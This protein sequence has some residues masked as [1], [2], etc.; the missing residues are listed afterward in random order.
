M[1]SAVSCAIVALLAAAL[2]PRAAA[3]FPAELAGRVV[4]ARTGG[5]VPGAAITADRRITTHA[6]AD[7]SFRLRGLEPREQSVR[8][9][10]VGY[11]P[12]EIT[13]TLANG[14]RRDLRLELRAM[15]V[16]LPELQTTARATEA[17]VTVVGR[18]EIDESARPDLPSLLDGR[19]GLVVE[20][21]GGAGGPATVSVRGSSAD[22]VLVLLDGVPLNDAVSG[23]ADLSLIALESLDSVVVR[24]GG[25]SAR[26]GGRALAGVLE[27]YSRRPS[28]SFEAAAG[29]RA[30]AWGDRGASGMIAGGRGAPGQRLSGTLT[31]EFRH[32]DGDFPF[33]VP[34]VRG[35]GEARRV[36]GVSRQATVQGSGAYEWSRGELRL[37]GDWLDVDRGMPGTIVQQ[38][39]SA[40]QAQRRVSGGVSSRADLG[41][42]TWTVDAGV[43]RQHAGF[44]DSLPP[45]GGAYDDSL[46]AT[47]V[48][49][50]SAAAVVRG[51]FDGSVGVDLRLLDVDGS[52]LAATAPGSRHYGGLWTSLALRR[53]WGTDGTVQLSAG[54]RGDVGSGVGDA[55][56]SPKV[57]VGAQ[58][59][60]WGVTA[61]WGMSFSPPSLGDQ[62]F[63]EGVQVRANPNL[64]PE[65]VR[66]EFTLA[67]ELRE[68][69]VLG[70]AVRAALTGFAANVDG[71]ILWTPDFRY[72]WSPAN[73][74]IRRRGAEAE[75]GVR[76]PN[77][78]AGLTMNGAFTDMTYT[79][80]VLTG[81]VVYRPRWTGNV[82]AD[83]EVASVR[84]AA[85]FRAV[86]ARRTAIGSP[87]NQLPAFAVFDLSLARA[88]ALGSTV[89]EL[90]GGVDDLFDRRAALIVDYPSPGR[91]WWLGT[92]LTVGGR[93]PSSGA[94]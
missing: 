39:L 74:N 92:R 29:A 66:S 19:A 31:G 30:G 90:R 9:V 22:E 49:V 79:G 7:G 54:A 86:G 67:L 45:F 52:A 51:A 89:L 20:R 11:A 85:S 81:Q 2:P 91:T 21:R 73:F 40:T 25:A 59:G 60:A 65:R 80:E 82:R 41:G 62:F 3:Q 70:A 57:T 56:V 16:A 53:P 55:V 47:T 37:R 44:R 61:S 27:L 58:R 4:D 69:R 76:L 83:A 38:S 93:G 5:A 72:V 10:A 18:K 36:N 75:L 71:M 23:S 24:R 84:A 46:R 15:A 28:G 88:F 42:V 12:T 33:D 63:Q 14:E 64:A 50:Q 8:V 78:R 43:Q 26:Y 13:I 94:R 34:A 68:Q 77:G 6:D 32:L 35:G 17:G 48:E 1:R 87:L